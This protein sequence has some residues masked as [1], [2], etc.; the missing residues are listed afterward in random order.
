[1]IATVTVDFD[2]MGPGQLK[3]NKAEKIIVIDFKY[4]EGWAHVSSMDGQRVG[5]FP[6]AFLLRSL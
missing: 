2:P 1:M 3:F 5:I 4:A 6:Q